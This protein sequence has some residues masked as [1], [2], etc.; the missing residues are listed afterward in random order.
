MVCFVKRLESDHHA[1]FLV[2]EAHFNKFVYFKLCSFRNWVFQN[3]VSLVWLRKLLGQNFKI[4][5]CAGRKVKVLCAGMCTELCA[6]DIARKEGV[7][8]RG[9][10]AKVF[11]WSSACRV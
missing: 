2:C 8:H 9:M 10:C 6:L 11:T 1:P 7:A 4:R 5:Q 3:S